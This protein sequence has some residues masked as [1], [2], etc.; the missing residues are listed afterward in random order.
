MHVRSLI[1]PLTALATTGLWADE[2]IWLFDQFPKA[3]V[4]RTYGVTLPDSL[5]DRIRQSSVRLNIGGS[6]SFVSPDGLIVT[7]HHVASMCIQ[8]LSSKTTDYMKDGFYAATRAAEKP[9]PDLEVN[10]LL[11]SDDVTAKVRSVW[12]KGKDSAD[13]ARLVKTQMARIEKACADSTGNR[14]DVVALYSGE[15]FHLYQ[16]RKYTDIRLV[17]APE[18][19]IAMFGGDPDNYTYPRYCLDVSFLRAYENGKP[20]RVEHFLTWSR[21]GAREGELSLVSG[22]PANTGRLAT[23]AELEFDRD[24]AYP[25]VIDHLRGLIADLEAYSAVNAENKRIAADDLFDI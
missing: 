18:S 23:M 21:A 1:L 11:K 10:I 20:V 12:G 3:L 14:C 9:C 22:H 19:S 8:Q 2:G 7:N 13:S 24:V 5:L 17:F 4:E 25:F 15:A 16:Y 6:G